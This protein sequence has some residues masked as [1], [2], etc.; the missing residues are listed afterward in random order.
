LQ[1]IAQKE[2]M[3][4]VDHHPLH[5]MDSHLEQQGYPIKLTEKALE[6]VPPG[7]VKP[8]HPVNRVLPVR[9]HHL[10]DKKD[11][12][13]EQQVYP[14][15]LT[16]KALPEDL[17]QMAHHLVCLETQARLDHNLAKKRVSKV[18]LMAEGLSK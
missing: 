12:L 4:R 7:Q 14:T 1:K 17:Q 10:Q 11:S 15:K 8:D 6:E 16:A 18:L 13:Q 2:L 3:K 5:K 9:H